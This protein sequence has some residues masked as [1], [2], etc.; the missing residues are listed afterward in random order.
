MCPLLKPNHK[1]PVFGWLFRTSEPAHCPGIQLCPGHNIWDVWYQHKDIRF[2]IKGDPELQWN[3]ATL[4]VCKGP[5][6]SVGL[7]LVYDSPRNKNHICFSCLVKISFFTP[8][9]CGVPLHRLIRLLLYLQIAADRQTTAI[10]ESKAFSQTAFTS[11][12]G[13]L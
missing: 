13:S 9:L 8:P 7:G 6:V 12:H 3:T 5:D 10:F 4:N 1:H 11:Q 2:L